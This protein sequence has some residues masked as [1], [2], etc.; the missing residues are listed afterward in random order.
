MFY[1]NTIKE[2]SPPLYF[3]SLVYPELIL[4]YL[5]YLNWGLFEV[6]LKRKLLKASKKN[7][8][9]NLTTLFVTVMAVRAR[10]LKP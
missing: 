8:V 9:W 7:N 1:K 5:G 6:P 2:L 3:I 4:K 10:R